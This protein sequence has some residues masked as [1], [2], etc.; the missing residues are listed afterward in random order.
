MGTWDEMGTHQGIVPTRVV[1]SSAANSAPVSQGV[2]EQGPHV[3]I[4]VGGFADGTSM[5]PFFIYQGVRYG[6]EETLDIVKKAPDALYTKTPSGGSESKSMIEF[7]DGCVLP[8]RPASKLLMWMILYMDQFEFHANDLLFLNHCRANRVAVM[9]GV[10]HATHKASP[11]D[12]HYNSPV[13]R[14]IRKGT[15]DFY[16]RCPL[17]TMSKGDFMDVATTAYD[18]VMTPALVKAGF[19]DTGLDVENVQIVEKLK[20]KVTE[21]SD[22]A[23]AA[24]TQAL[25]RPLRSRA[26]SDAPLPTDLAA[27]WVLAPGNVLPAEPL[28]SWSRID[29]YNALTRVASLGHRALA[30][31]A[32]KRQRRAQEGGLDSAARELTAPSRLVA[33]EAA[34]AAKEQEAARAVAASAALKAKQTHKCVIA[35]CTS[36]F[37]TAKALKKHVEKRHTS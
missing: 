25:A 20:K 19:H 4:G 22:T 9:G 37:T 6:A 33:L 30:E 2:G 17:E 35:L 7:L 26:V 13:I 24:S 15:V 31:P 28:A 10:P 12:T 14:A 27:S 21:A 23:I 3:T 11:A 5:R 34:K 29:I 1:T 8:H 18:E 16:G 32:L 36:A